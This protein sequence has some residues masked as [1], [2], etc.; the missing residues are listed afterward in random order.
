M[1]LK[2]ISSANLKS[3]IK[4]RKFVMGHRQSQSA[5][6]ADNETRHG[7]GACRKRLRRTRAMQRALRVAQD[8]AQLAADELLTLVSSETD[9]A[10][11][12]EVFEEAGASPARVSRRF[13]SEVD[14]PARLRAR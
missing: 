10:D 8:E 4:D 2:S 13:A 3:K 7:I 12:E 14:R 6:R 11:S 9:F 5:E 1:E